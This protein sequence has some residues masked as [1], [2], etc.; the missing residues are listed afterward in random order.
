M[1]NGKNAAIAS[2]AGVL[3]AVVVYFVLG[4][5]QLQKQGGQPGRSIAT[6]SPET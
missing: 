4:L 6:D 1:K 3:V 5:L 2:G